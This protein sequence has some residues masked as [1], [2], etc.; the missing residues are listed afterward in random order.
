[1]TLK[2][3]GKKGKSNEVA[4]IQGAYLDIPDDHVLQLLQIIDANGIGGYNAL[5]REC[6]KSLILQTRQGAL[7]AWPPEFLLQDRANERLVK[8]RW[9]HAKEYPRKPDKKG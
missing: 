7:I 5:F 2:S 8:E 6:V 3:H 9:E 1:M 4:K